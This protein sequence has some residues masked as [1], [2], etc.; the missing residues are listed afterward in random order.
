MLN[1]NAAFMS[2]PCALHVISLNGERGSEPITQ[3]GGAHAGPQY[4]K[5]WASIH[6]EVH[7]PKNRTVPTVWKELFHEDAT[8]S[9]GQASDPGD[10]TVPY[11]RGDTPVAYKN[12]VIQPQAGL[13]EG[14]SRHVKICVS[15]VTFSHRW[16]PWRFRRTRPGI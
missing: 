8:A 12:K 16:P 4:G 14:T 1:S 15:T 11:G 3:T 6:G 10:A 7:D 5:S 2:R 13:L 9:P